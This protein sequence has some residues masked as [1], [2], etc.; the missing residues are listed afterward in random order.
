MFRTAGTPHQDSRLEAAI[1]YA[2]LLLASLAALGYFSVRFVVRDQLTPS[3]PA[4]V[5]IPVATFAV[6]TLLFFLLTRRALVR[7]HPS[8]AYTVSCGALALPL[9]VLGLATWSQH[10]TA[11]LAALE[12][13]CS[14][15][16]TIRL[17]KPNGEAVVRTNYALSE[18]H[19]NGDE[20]AHLAAAQ[21]IAN[22]FGAPQKMRELAHRDGETAPALFRYD[23]AYWINRAL[24][25]HPPGLA[26]LYAPAASNPPFARVVALLFTMVAAWAAFWMGTQHLGDRS[27]GLLF[28]AV[29]LGIPNLIWW[30][31]ASVSSDIPPCVPAYLAFGTLGLAGVWRE[32]E[33]A[34][35]TRLL[36]V[37]GF[38]LGMATLI[39]YT[40]AVPAA[41]GA[42]AVY[43][44]ETRWKKLTKPALLVGPAAVAVGIEIWYARNVFGDG[45]HVLLHRLATLAGSCEAG[46]YIAGVRG[47][48]TFLVRLP[49]DVGPPLLVLFCGGILQQLVDRCRPIGR[50]LKDLMVGC[51]VL[52]PAS[53]LFWPEIR[54]AFPALPFL[55]YGFGVTTL[56]DK[57][58][59]TQKALT[60]GL[61]GGFSYTKFVL[62]RLAV[63]V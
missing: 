47:L 21:A 31:A 63:P 43:F 27:L 11:H 29:F 45:G 48:K 62:T 24:R 61:I 22:T 1:R 37:A 50:R 53:S 30:H 54:F 56:W 51:A 36:A 52:I 46:P 10:F 35:N 32:P 3:T 40:A 49:M 9:L 59:S 8:I 39:T 34:S 25:G 2:A 60:I 12:D 4:N 13:I 17:W 55:C 41:A 15:Y 7:P 42:L 20:V 57:M 5:A 28:L 58:S 14:P 44:R 19:R 33:Q 38:L 16:G 6:S 26:V 23:R 18:L